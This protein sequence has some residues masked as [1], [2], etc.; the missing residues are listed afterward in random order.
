MRVALCAALAAFAL[1]SCS[2]P[3]PSAQLVLIKQAMDA[4]VKGDFKTFEDVAAQPAAAAEPGKSVADY[5]KA[6][7]LAAT[8]ARRAIALANELHG[9]DVSPVFSM[10][11]EARYVYLSADITDASRLLA[12][13]GARMGCEKA[14]SAV[15]GADIDERTRWIGAMETASHTW[16]V[17]L[18]QQSPADFDQRL[19]TASDQLERNHLGHFTEVR[20]NY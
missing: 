8:D 19:N 16:W 2:S 1:C 20:S 7:T 9:L 14:D 5:D 11:D 4:Y 12:H 6:C 15:Y 10:S 17:A 13:S 3:P 18:R